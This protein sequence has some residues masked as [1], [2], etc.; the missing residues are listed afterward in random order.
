M[1]ILKNGNDL[2]LLFYD[3][4]KHKFLAILKGPFSLGVITADLEIRKDDR[5]IMLPKEAAIEGILNNVPQKQDPGA[6]EKLR[7][8]NRNVFESGYA[9]RKQFT[10]AA[11]ERIIFI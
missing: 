4:K 10:G 11:N 5:F 9:A 7:K 6:N 3:F 2:R 1:S 8:L